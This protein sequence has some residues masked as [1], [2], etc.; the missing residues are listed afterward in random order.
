[1]LLFALEYLYARYARWAGKIP[2]LRGRSY[3]HSYPNH[4]GNGIATHQVGRR[5]LGGELAKVE[6]G[7]YPGEGISAETQV[8]VQTED[9]G[10]VDGLF[11][12]VCRPSMLVYFAR[13]PRT[14][15]L[16]SINKHSIKKPRMGRGSRGTEEG[17]LVHWKKYTKVIAGMIIKSIFRR[18]ARSSAGSMRYSTETSR[19]EPSSSRFSSPVDGGL[20]GSE[21][22]RV[23][24]SIFAVMELDLSPRSAY[25]DI[26]IRTL[27]DN[28]DRERRHARRERVRVELAKRGGK[29]G[30]GSTSRSS[31]GCDDGQT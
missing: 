29:R 20:A 1:M 31:P 30:D 19:N 6:E 21:L 16:H 8:G 3:S 9:G 11:V 15:P 5:E 23:A 7:Y 10:I 28:S 4:F 22:W 25:L 24:V 12:E 13:H 17:R 2:A 14:K 18:T 26:G 27:S